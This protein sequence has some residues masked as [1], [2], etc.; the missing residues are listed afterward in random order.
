MEVKTKPTTESQLVV[1]RTEVLDLDNS[2]RKFNEG[3]KQ[4]VQKV[5]QINADLVVIQDTKEG[6]FLECQSK[7]FDAWQL[8]NMQLQ[9]YDLILQ[10]RK[11]ELPKTPS[12]VG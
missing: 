11:G 10:K 1:N 5:Q 9:T 3:I 6:I 8:I 4:E 12:G 2:L 7:K